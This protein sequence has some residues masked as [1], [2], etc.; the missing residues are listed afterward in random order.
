M[1]PV[2]HKTQEDDKQEYI[3]QRY[4]Q[5]WKYKTQEDEKQKQIPYLPT[6]LLIV[7]V[8]NAKQTLF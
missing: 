3:T 2:L 6:H 7:W 1:L 8:G 5:H 4:R